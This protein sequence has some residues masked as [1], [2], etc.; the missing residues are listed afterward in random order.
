M[1]H[2]L[3]MRSRTHVVE[4]DVPRSNPQ[5]ALDEE[6]TRSL[7]S[8]AAAAAVSSTGV[9]AL[10][11][12]PVVRYVVLVKGAPEEIGTRLAVV[13]AQYHASYLHY[14]G[15]GYRVLALAYKVSN[16]GVTFVDGS[17]YLVLQMSDSNDQVST[18]I[19]LTVRVMHM[20]SSHVLPMRSDAHACSPSNVHARTP[21]QELPH[22]KFSGE[23]R[24][25]L[26][27]DVE[28]GLTFA[29][30]LILSCPLKPDSLSAVTLVSWSPFFELFLSFCFARIQWS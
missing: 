26:R 4:L 28:S 20:F 24:S 11:A 3:G 15:R 10:A 22:I 14:S 12:A 23:L 17:V 6:T 19:L 7:S 25:L 5:Q 9:A 2:A 30:F 8:S 1:R 18:N 29:G 16:S 13:P 27:T 21:L